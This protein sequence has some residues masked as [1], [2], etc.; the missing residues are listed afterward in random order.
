MKLSQRCAA[1]AKSTGERCGNRAILGATVCRVHGGAAPQV[2]KAAAAR[3]EALTHPALDRLEELL[4]TEDDPA[5]LLRV[6]LAVLDRVG[7]HPSHGVE[8]SGH[9]DLSDLSDVELA[10]MV[11]EDPA[12]RDLLHAEADDDLLPDRAPTAS[13]NGAPT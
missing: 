7:F 4:E 11:L 10:R 12:I 13:D 8:L 1:R 9:L 5:I 3:L 6:V 2:R